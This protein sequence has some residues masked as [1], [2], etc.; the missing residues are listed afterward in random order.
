[1]TPFPPEVCVHWIYDVIGGIAML[2]LGFVLVGTA[3]FYKGWDEGF[4]DGYNKEI[5]ER[6]GGS[7]AKP[8][9]QPLNSPRSTARNG[10]PTRK[11]S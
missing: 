11:A 4:R 3:A 5:S 2:A 6:F 1:L 7:K 9:T 10:F 8:G